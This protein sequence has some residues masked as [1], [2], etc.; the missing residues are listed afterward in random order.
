MHKIKIHINPIFINRINPAEFHFSKFYFGSNNAVPLRTLMGEYQSIL[1][2]FW[3]RI[4][5]NTTKYIN[6]PL[7]SL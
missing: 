5:T 7:M 1:L 2:G 4:L 6:N 3:V